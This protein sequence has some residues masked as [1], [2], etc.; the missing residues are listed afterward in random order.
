MKTPVPYDAKN[1]PL[2]WES[3]FDHYNQLIAYVL[4]ENKRNVEIDEIKK[5]LIQIEKL[6]K[7]G[8]TK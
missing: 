3:F 8:N 1:I 4:Q 6:I 2:E 7:G 5:K